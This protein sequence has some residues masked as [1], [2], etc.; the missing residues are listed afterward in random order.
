MGL[1]ASLASLGPGAAISDQTPAESE[2]ERPSRLESR[3]FAASGPGFY[4]WEEDSKQGRRWAAELERPP[5]L[6]DDY[7]G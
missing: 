6:K 5:V 1:V 2:R 3:G 7:F 4:V